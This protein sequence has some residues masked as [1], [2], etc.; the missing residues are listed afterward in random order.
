[1]WIAL[2]NLSS[3]K[4]FLSIFITQITFWV[5][6]ARAGEESDVSHY[7]GS[8]PTPLHTHPCHIH[9]HTVSSWPWSPR[10]HLVL[11]TLGEAW[12]WA[13][14]MV[15]MAPS[16]HFAKWEMGMV[17]SQKCPPMLLVPAGRFHKCQSRA[18]CSKATY[19]WAPYSDI[20]HLWVL[21]GNKGWGP[22][23]GFTAP[24]ACP[25]PSWPPSTSALEGLFL[26]SSFTVRFNDPSGSPKRTKLYDHKS[27]FTFPAHKRVL[28]F[29]NAIIWPAISQG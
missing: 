25:F 24:P 3:R 23:T 13:I 18:A 26:A 29:R 9:A 20:C 15:T 28:I 1:M 10:A 5:F 27:L 21:Y 11:G 22:Q 7:L 17:S 2:W 6:L 8:F 19:L 16:I 4:H 12:S 14:V